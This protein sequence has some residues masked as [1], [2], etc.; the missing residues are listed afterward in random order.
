MKFP[1]IPTDNLY[2][3]MAI[4]GIVILVASFFPFFHRYRLRLQTINLAGE[5]LILEM[6]REQLKDEL[7]RIKE[8]DVDPILQHYDKLQ[9]EIASIIDK[10]GPNAKIPTGLWKQ[11]K[12][13]EIRHEEV[14]VEMKDVLHRLREINVANIQILTKELEIKYILGIM[15]KELEFVLFASLSGIILAALGFSLWYKKLQAPQDLIIKQKVKDD[16]KQ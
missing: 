16:Q 11:S 4:S 9:E 12:G 1:E 14:S 6:Q 2:K 10:K 7:K 15:R 13:L 8:Y 3:F 5:K